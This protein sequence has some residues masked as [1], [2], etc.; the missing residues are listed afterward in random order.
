MH[1]IENGCAGRQVDACLRVSL[2]DLRMRDRLLSEPLRIF[3]GRESRGVIP[4]VGQLVWDLSD[5]SDAVNHQRLSIHQRGV[6]LP[7][8]GPTLL[9]N[10]ID[11]HATLL[12]S[13]SPFARSSTVQSRR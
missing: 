1:D 10:L 7:R 13:V 5:R 3:Q 2:K 9:H 11:Y 4:L 6:I 8:F 12:P